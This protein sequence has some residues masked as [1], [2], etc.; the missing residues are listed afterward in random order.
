MQLPAYRGRDNKEQI[1]FNQDGEPLNFTSAGITSA[2]VIV[3]GET[4]PAEIT[5]TDNNIISVK[6]GSLT[7]RPGIYDAFVVVI[8]ADDP[9]GKVIAGP[10]QAIELSVKVLL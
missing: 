10:G 9:A 4:I 8:S 5:G 1:Q 3:N 6:L 7:L 2:S